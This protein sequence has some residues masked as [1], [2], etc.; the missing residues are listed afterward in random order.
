MTSQWLNKL[1]D[2][3]GVP[4]VRRKE[5]G[6]LEIF[7]EEKAAKWAACRTRPKKKTSARARKPDVW[8]EFVNRGRTFESREVR[9][10]IHLAIAATNVGIRASKAY[11]DWSIT[12]L[13]EK[14]NVSRQGIY[15]AIARLERQ[16]PGVRGRLLFRYDRPVKQSDPFWNP[17]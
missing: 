5:N 17:V 15:Q 8:G 16:I 3:N 10:S 12:G 13:A 6:R 2:R 9:A 7:D 1:L 11:S 4:G 14:Y